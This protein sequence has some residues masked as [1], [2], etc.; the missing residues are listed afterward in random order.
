MEKAG[1]QVLAIS[2]DDKD[3]LKRFKAE[4]KA[5]FA[6]IPD[7]EGK[8]IE[9]YDVKMPMVSYAKRYSFVVGADRKIIKTQSGND[10]VNP[11][12]AIAACPLKKKKQG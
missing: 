7:P 2:M 5:P 8:I 3:T 12:E 1:A 10:A 9:L 11:D 6:F 4:L